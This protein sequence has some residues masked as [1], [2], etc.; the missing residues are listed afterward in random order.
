MAYLPPADPR[1]NYYQQSPVRGQ[2]ENPDGTTRSGWRYIQCTDTPN[3]LRVLLPPYTAQIYGHILNAENAELAKGKAANWE[4]I[5]QIRHLKDRMIRKCTRLSRTSQPKDKPAPR[6]LFQTVHAPPDFRLKE[7]ERWYKLQG[8][9]LGKSSRGP[10]AAPYCKEC[11]ECMAHQART[12]AYAQQ[13]AVRRSP[14][15]SRLPPPRGSTPERMRM[16]RRQAAQQQGQ[17]GAYTHPAAPPVRQDQQRARGPAPARG[18]V[19]Y[20]SAPAVPGYHPDPPRPSQGRKPSEYL[21]AD[22]AARVQARSPDP[23]P[24]PYRTRPPITS[25]EPEPDPS[26]ATEVGPVPSPRESITPPKVSTPPNGLPTIHEE[27]AEHR[28]IVRRRSSLK[29]RDSMSKLSV[30]SQSKSVAWAMDKDWVDQMSQYVK[31]SNEAE[32]LNAELEK[33]RLEYHDEI[34]AMRALCLKV[35]E[36]QERVRVETEHLREN[37]KAVKTQENKILASSEQIEL[38]QAEFQAKVL[39]VLEESKRVV[40]LCDK[41]RDVHETS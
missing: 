5:L 37:E 2:L 14:S 31:T 41:K 8:G 40:Q 20:P 10:A 29:K 32:V 22:H 12:Q 3:E 18:H 4:R 24:I 33:L 28:P 9:E 7:M 6:V 17:P 25:P 11:Q 16:A 27:E 38:K 39:A 21:R 36:S 15:S 19:R 1:L 30:A 35:E 26:E 23:L 34:E 13:A